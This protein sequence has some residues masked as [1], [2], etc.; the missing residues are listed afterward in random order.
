MRW[1]GE[2]YFCPV[3]NVISDLEVTPYIGGAP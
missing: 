1:L 3:Y 2:S